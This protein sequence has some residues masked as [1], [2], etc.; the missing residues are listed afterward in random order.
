[1]NIADDMCLRPQN[2]LTPLNRTLNFPINNDAFGCNDS[3]NM[4]PRAI[5]R[6]VQWSSPSIWPLTSLSPLR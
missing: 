5:R 4:R 2:Y 1:M 3:V 6:D